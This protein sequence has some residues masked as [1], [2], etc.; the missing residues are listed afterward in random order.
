MYSFF[1]QIPVF[2]NGPCTVLWSSTYHM[3]Y[4]PFTKNYYILYNSIWLSLIKGNEI[5]R[6]KKS[7]KTSA[8]ICFLLLLHAI[9]THT[10]TVHP[11]S[12]D[13][14]HIYIRQV[15]DIAITMHWRH[16]STL[17]SLLSHK[18]API[19]SKRPLSKYSINIMS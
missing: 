8:T 15:A 11:H 10:P 7:H 2:F 9:I 5:G 14:T 18:K 12:V 1:T 13:C 3:Y 17:S 19:S 4:T 6:V 16:F